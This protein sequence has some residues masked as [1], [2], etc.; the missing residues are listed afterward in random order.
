MGHILE[1]DTTWRI[2]RSNDIETLVAVIEVTED[3]N[4]VLYVSGQDLDFLQ[5]NCHWRKVKTRPKQA[6]EEKPQD[7]KIV[8][9][10]D[11]PVILDAYQPRHNG[12][13]IDCNEEGKTTIDSS[14]GKIQAIYFF[15]GVKQSDWNE[16]ILLI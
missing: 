14:V 10:F 2:I 16:K 11:Q 13:T 4:I 15:E 7:K 8:L 6:P 12:I 3:G 9:T 5:A 1:K